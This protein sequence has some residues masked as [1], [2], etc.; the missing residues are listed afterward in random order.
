MG[1]RWQTVN[2]KELPGGGISISGR[3]LSLE[4]SLLLFFSVL[5]E[6]I[7]LYFIIMGK[8][9]IWYGAL[10]AII[11]F[12]S[13]FATRYTITFLPDSA[14]VSMRFL[15]RHTVHIHVPGTHVLLN[16]KEQIYSSKLYSHL[17]EE[18]KKC[19]LVFDFDGDW[20]VWDYVVITYGGK[21]YSFT[22]ANSSFEKRLWNAIVAAF[23]QVYADRQGQVTED[24]P[25]KLHVLRGATDI[26]SFFVRAPFLSGRTHSSTS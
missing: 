25:G 15:G 10:W 17:A 5:L 1:F 2:V 24:D 18:E 16:A 21:H 13:V 20:D 12:L 6:V 9:S 22:S 23:K 4:G 19:Y 7:T 3:M 11:A 14:A 8:T 26:Y